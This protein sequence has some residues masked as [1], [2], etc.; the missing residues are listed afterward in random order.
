MQNLKLLI[1]IF[2]NLMKENGSAVIHDICVHFCPYKKY[3]SLSE[4]FVQF[5]AYFKN[6]I[7]IIQQE[8]VCERGCLCVRVCVCVT[9]CVCVYDI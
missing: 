8:F 4:N 7:Y 2:L 5:Y 3:L 9:V 6:C 1:S